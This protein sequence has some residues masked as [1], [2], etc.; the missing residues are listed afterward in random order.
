MQYKTTYQL[1]FEY[2]ARIKHA[3]LISTQKKQLDE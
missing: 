3:V 2:E 1:P